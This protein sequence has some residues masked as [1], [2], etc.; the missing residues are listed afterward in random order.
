VTGAFGAA[1]GGATATQPSTG[2]FGSVTGS[3]FGSSGG[4]G[5]GKAAGTATGGGFGAGASAAIKTPGGFGKAATS[6]AGG[7]GK[8]SVPGTGGGGFGKT[9]GTGGFGVKPGGGGFG[10]VKNDDGGSVKKEG[11]GGF[12]IVK[13]EGGGG[14]GFGGMKNEGGGGFGSVKKEGGGGFGSVKAAEAGI[15][16]GAGAALMGGFGKKEGG[17]GF[18]SVKA[19]EGGIGFGAGAALTGG[20]GKQGG[21][22]GTEGGGFGKPAGAWG[23]SATKGGKGSKGKGKGDNKGEGKGKGRGKGKG[24][25]GKG[26]EEVEAPEAVESTGFGGG[27]GKKEIPGFG[28]SS[29][30]FG[31]GF[32]SKPSL[33]GKSEAGGFGKS[34]SGFASLGGTDMAKKASGDT[35][36]AGGF[37]SMMS[38]KPSVGFGSAM[39]P[40]TAKAGLGG[41]GGPSPLAPHM[42]RRTPGDAETPGAG[43]EPGPK[44]SPEAMGGR[45][46]G[47]AGEERHLVGVKLPEGMNARALG[48]HV[49]KSGKVTE[50]KFDEKSRILKVCFAD[51]EGLKHL[52]TEGSVVTHPTTGAQV[53]LETFVPK[54]RGSSPPPKAASTFGTA[55]TTFG[56][57]TNPQAL[58][59]KKSYVPSK[60]VV[61]E[62]EEDG[63]DD[64]GGDSG[65][66]GFNLVEGSVERPTGAGIRSRL[67][68]KVENKVENTSKPPAFT[69]GK[70]PAFTGGKPPSPSEDGDGR[71][72]SPPLRLNT[73]AANRFIA[74]A[75]GLSSRKFN[76][77]AQDA[78]AARLSGSLE[79]YSAYGNK[80]DEAS[81]GKGAGEEDDEEERKKRRANRFGDGSTALAK[82]R[83]REAEAAKS[84]PAAGIPPKAPAFAGHTVAHKAAAGGEG[85]GESPKAKTLP[86][87]QSLP[88][89]AKP[90][91]Q[92]AEFEL[93][94]D[95]SRLEGELRLSAYT[96][97]IIE[98]RHK[99]GDLVGTCEAME[100]EDVL[101]KNLAEGLSHK[102]YEV[103]ESGEP[104]IDYHI[105][106]NKRTWQPH[107]NHEC[108]SMLSIIRVMRWIAVKILDSDTRG[109]A[110]M[111][112]F[113]KYGSTNF[114]VMYNFV[115]GRYRQIRRELQCQ[116]G[117]E[118]P[119]SVRVHEQMVRFTIFSTYMLQP[120]DWDPDSP[121]KL[122]EEHK[123]IG[124]CFVTL[125]ACYHNPDFPIEGKRCE[126]EMKAYFIILKAHELQKAG[127]K[128]SLSE[129]AKAMRN[130]SR[131]VRDHPLIKYAWE[132]F[133]ALGGIWPWD[134]KKQLNHAKFFKMLLD[135]AV[136]FLLTCLLHTMVDQVRVA[137]IRNTLKNSGGVPGLDRTVPRPSPIPIS[138]IEK[139][140]CFDDE[141][142]CLRWCEFY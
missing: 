54:K 62:E 50:W 68:L 3:T 27:F 83:A 94:S 44:R 141:E 71:D 41:L 12:G 140:L 95:A 109:F 80:A 58:N 93:E 63:G 25:L 92:G 31:S 36:G 103:G 87:R 110:G 14:G 124:K 52:K 117:V 59:P 51:V 20:F 61:Y 40:V 120:N 74:G 99:N 47:G 126:A 15:G 106:E 65:V 105:T 18:G 132:A 102:V 2:G 139:M 8:T 79:E 82:A 11:G 56:N 70:P 121:L 101:A 23:A 125:F 76:A 39:K 34:T 116:G 19:A 64:G 32:N 123:K 10:S 131:E 42:G 113:T 48:E 135:P 60:A 129:I 4:A 28:M 13:K 86:P 85:S 119:E 33:L 7:F 75:M 104:K 49:K 16:F 107:A 78:K 67:G 37:G 108:R 137:A 138:K 133:E 127:R 6:L 38:A 88:R 84:T 72:K 89:M 21:G 96:A 111:T 26:G 114:L 22:F 130:V 45:G 55:P 73:K 69:G 98:R 43:A 29:G 5:F 77:E 115:D 53:N 112:D 1:A 90:T 57:T 91:I 17:G 35:L 97:A 142:V 134:S 128:D 9:E 46:K 24:G 66:G 118:T 100:Q 136:P 30:A 122:R 81:P